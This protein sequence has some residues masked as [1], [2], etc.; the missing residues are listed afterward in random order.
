VRSGKRRGTEGEVKITTC[1]YDCGGRCVLRVHVSS[2]VI[3]RISTDDSP[4]PGLKACSRGLSQKDVVYAPDR[5]RQP[6]RRTGRRG[7][8]EFQAISWEEALDLVASQLTRVKERYGP[9]SIFL[10]DY[11]GSLSPLHGTLKS[12]RRFFSFF[13][14]CTTNWGN[15]SLEAAQFSSLATFGTIFTGTTRDNLPHAKL[16]IIWGWN[17]AITRFGPDTVPYL[18]QAKKGGTRII[19]VDPRRSPTTEAFASQWVPIRPGTDAALLIA[20]AQVMIAEGL[21]DER[22]IGTY[23]VGFERFRDY[24]L[25]QEDGIAKTPAW[26]EGI[27][28]V[29]AVTTRELAR[30][31]ATVKPAILWASWAPGRTAFGEQYHRA[32]SALA[33][34]TGNIGIQGGYAAGGTG[35]IPLG[36]FP[37]S[38]PVGE[39]DFPS[40]HVT[41]VFDALLLGKS[42][43]FPSDTALL[44]IVG[45]NFLNQFANTNKGAKAMMKPEFIVA[46]ELFLT[47]T[48]RYADVVLP[49]THFLEQQDLGQ[50]WT[51]GPYFIH[52]SQVIQPLPGVRSD[53]AVFAD[54]ASRLGIEGYNARSDEA[55]VRDFVDAT[56]ELPPF[57]EFKGKGVHR[58]DLDGPWIAFREEIKDPENHRFPTPSGKI[59]IYSQELAAMKNPLVPPIP[60]YLEAW[61]GWADPLRARYPLQLITPHSR[62]RVN[63]ALDNIPRLKALAEDRLWINPADAGARGIRN[64]DRVRVFNDRGCLI[65]VAKVTD[66]IIQGAVSLDQGAWFRPDAQGVDQGGCVNVLTRD[67]MSPAGAFACN[68][69]LVEVGP[70]EETPTEEKPIRPLAP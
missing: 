38:F 65:A 54:L 57:E 30:A 59:E 68:T 34:M 48:A 14:G 41:K 6:L 42:G 44:Y 61:E 11:Y 36:I 46:H 43:G 15:T 60:K 25:G 20:M 10:M 5:L 45:S 51:G 4:G 69:C 55:W 7:E 40:V 53:T 24:V 49:V 67:E 58:M 17:P 26:A 28:A 47:P 2:G 33:A 19:S 9:H 39:T 66:G 22:F 1:S 18:N 52:A 62:S 8:G 32:A 12:G 13:G 3:E 27:T 56:E 63:S 23:T 50:P 16:I 35:K 64:G 21:W 31:Y 29:P 37:K 70:L